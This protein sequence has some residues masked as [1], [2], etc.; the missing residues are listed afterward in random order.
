MGAITIRKND[1]YKLLKEI[2]RGHNFY[3]KF[4]IEDSGKD[5]NRD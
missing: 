5:T 2:H 4:R 3:T 1:I